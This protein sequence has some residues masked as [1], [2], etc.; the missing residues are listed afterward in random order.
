M[1]VGFPTY[2]HCR[3]S[4]S[5]FSSF[6][7]EL[8]RLNKF[9]FSWNCISITL[10]FLFPYCCLLITSSSFYVQFSRYIFVE[11][12]AAHSVSVRTFR[13]GRKLHI[14][15]LLLLSNQNPLRWAFDWFGWRLSLFSKAHWNPRLE[16][17]INLQKKVLYSRWQAKSGI[18]SKLNNEKFH[19][20]NFWFDFVESFISSSSSRRTPWTYWP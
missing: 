6:F 18:P 17:S 13:S 7:Q 16:T 5:G 4:I 19:K 11:A 10:K 2:K 9:S 15:L 12:N 8:C 20:W 14:A 3:K 1:F